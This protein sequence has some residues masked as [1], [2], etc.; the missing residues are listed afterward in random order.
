MKLPQKREHLLLDWQEDLGILWLTL[1]RPKAHNAIDFDMIEGIEEACRL[2]EG[3]DEVRVL[4]IRALGKSFCAGGD[5]KDMQ[6]QSGMFEGASMALRKNYQRGIQ[7]IPKALESLSIP[8]MAIVDGPAIG[9]GCDLA[10]MADMR[11]AGPHATFSESF[12]RLALVPGD[13]G[14]FFL[15]RIIGY[16]KAMEMFLTARTLN[17]QEA[18]D[19]G[20]VNFLV[21]DD[22]EKFACE[23]VKKMNQLAPEALSMTKEALKSAA[24]TPLEHH[25]NFL[26]TLQA[27]TQRGQD[28]FEALK[29]MQDKRAAHFK[30]S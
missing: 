5:I 18:Y 24:H 16:A 29:A 15:P 19:W 13:G 3:H 21:K 28:H 6:N 30:R 27:I 4:I 7:R 23:L 14:T 2:C 20:L 1:N 8:I 12:A 17:A 25:L 22:Q 26:S 10:C 11:I 9:A